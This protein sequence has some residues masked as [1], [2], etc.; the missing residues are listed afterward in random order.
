MLIKQLPEGV[1][2]KAIEY[3][4]EHDKEL[5]IKTMEELGLPDAFN[6]HATT[7]GYDYWELVNDD[8]PDS[9]EILLKSKEG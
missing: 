6:W 5:T 3:A 7:E 2:Q 9:A 4:M 1:R 8:L